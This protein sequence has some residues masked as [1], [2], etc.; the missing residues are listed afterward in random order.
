[1]SGYRVEGLRAPVIPLFFL[2]LLAI[3][4]GAAGQVNIEVRGSTLFERYEFSE[5]LGSSVDR[6]T[7]LSVPLT[8]S[9]QVGR[10][11][12][13]TVASGYAQVRLSN[14]GRKTALVRGVLDTE[15]RLAFQAVP[16][17]ITIFTT[18]SFPTGIAS[19]QQNDLSILGVLASEVIGFSSARLGGGGA[20]GGGVAASAPVGRMALGLAASVTANGTYRPIRRQPG[21]FSRVSRCGCDSGSRVP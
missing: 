12:A 5:T 8:L 19:V 9:A 2:T 14:Q 7:E 13:L 1:M 6:V 3:H 20:V 11:T 17:R 18:S 21:E 15:L 16:D 10:R 4:A